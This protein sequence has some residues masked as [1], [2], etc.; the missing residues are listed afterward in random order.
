MSKIVEVSEIVQ[1]QQIDSSNITYHEPNAITDLIILDQ[2]NAVQLAKI[3][4]NLLVSIIGTT[5]QMLDIDPF[6][7][8]MNFWRDDYNNELDSFVVLADKL[9]SRNA[10]LSDRLT[11]IDKVSDIQVMYD[12]AKVLVGE[13]LLWI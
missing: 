5:E 4:N 8:D 12:K 3:M 6:D 2:L 13:V 10:K 7:E 11:L 9:S 1:G